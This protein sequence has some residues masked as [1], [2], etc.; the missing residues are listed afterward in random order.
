LESSKLH[1]VGGISATWSA[2]Y[3]PAHLGSSEQFEETGENTGSI[4]GEATAGAVG[5]DK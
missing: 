4:D 1:L 5:A 3:F 2:L